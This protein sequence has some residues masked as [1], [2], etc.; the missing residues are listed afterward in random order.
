MNFVIITT[1]YLQNYGFSNKILVHAYLTCGETHIHGCTH[2]HAHAHTHIHTHTHTY[3]THVHINIHTHTFS[4]MHTHKI[5]IIRE[6]AVA[7]L[8]NR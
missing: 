8:L 6:I 2:T 4:Y 5:A 3:T 7:T 1:V